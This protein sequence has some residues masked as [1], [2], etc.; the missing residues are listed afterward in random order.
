MLN[1]LDS[2]DMARFVSLAK[3]DMTALRLATLFQ[4]T[5]PGATSIYYYGDEIGLPCGHDPLNR[6]A[7]PWDSSAWVSDLLHEF[8]RLIALRKARPALRRGSYESLVASDDV[9]V[10]LRTLGDE[11]IV[12]ALNTSTATRRVEIPLSGRVSDGSIL[13][14]PWSREGCRV[15]AGRFGPIELAPR[16]GRVFATPMGPR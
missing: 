13:E 5:D 10:H 3:G 4:M 7:F 8:Q 9:H 11:A 14:A 16:S 2:H 1:L 15:E 6:A 12:V